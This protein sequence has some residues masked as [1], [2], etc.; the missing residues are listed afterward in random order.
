[1]TFDIITLFDLIE[2][3]CL[4]LEV[5]L[6]AKRRLE[7]GGILD[8][9][10][11]VSQ[12]TGVQLLP[13]RGAVVAGHAHAHQNRVYEKPESPDTQADE[14]FIHAGPVFHDFTQ[15]RGDKG[16]DD[17]TNNAMALSL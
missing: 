8:D 4:P 11:V 16:R 1:M 14:D 17:K 12:G 2:H 15:G 10:L 6:E 7:P 13:A 9:L 5:I 3:V